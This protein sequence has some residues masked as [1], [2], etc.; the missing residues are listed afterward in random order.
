MR[1][2]RVN[3]YLLMIEPGI[4]VYLTPELEKTLDE[5]AVQQLVNAS[6]LPGVHKV[7]ALPD[8]HAG[9]GLPVGGVMATRTKDGV[10]SPGAVGVDIN[11]GVRLLATDLEEKAVTKKETRERLLAGFRR[12]I[13]AGEGKNEIGRAHV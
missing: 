4:E 7:L 12:E 10:I 13:P 2:Q 8:V 6:L 5:T 1:W 3:N 9:Y 11:C